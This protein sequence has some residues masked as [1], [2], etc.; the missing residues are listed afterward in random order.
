MTAPAAQTI[1][2]EETLGILAIGNNLPLL[3]K[4]GAEFVLN[5]SKGVKPCCAWDAGS[6]SRKPHHNRVE[7]HLCLLLDMGGTH[8][9]VGYRDSSG[10]WNPILDHHNDWFESKRDPSLP[11]L[12]AFFRTL[13]LE[14]L[15]ACPALIT[16][17]LPIRLGVI[18]S[19]QIKTRRFENGKTRGVTG[20]V[21]GYQSGGYRKGEWFLKEIKNGDD[22]GATLLA[23]CE[24]ASLIPE[25][26]VLG[27]DTLF[28]LF[29]VADAHA[30]VVMS[31]G[32]NCTLVGTED[33]DKDELFNSELGGMLMIPAELLSAGDVAFMKSR[34]ISSLSLEELSAG[35]WFPAMVASHIIEASVTPGGDDLKQLADDIQA[36]RLVV[37][38]RSLSGFLGGAETIFSAYPEASRSALYPLV[39]AL[40]E[41]GA[42]L[43]GLLC[44]LSVV[45]QIQAGLKVAVVSLDSS[46]A[47]HFP[48]YLEGMKRAVA[49][50]SPHGVTIDLRLMT[51]L[52]IAEGIEISVPLQGAAA[53]LTN[54]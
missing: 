29:A 30:G 24:R 12:Q 13:L 21:H 19:N 50:L 1:P 11:R 15:Q 32:G 44:Y 43:A 28:T 6:L 20:L 49:A 53:A 46:M 54:H 48:L 5:A 42:I 36:K 45:G 9:K 4:L 17:K 2:L 39:A 23:E 41:R 8:T 27:N 47:R 33:R 52:N 25:V 22:V 18:W 31:S 16:T 40:V 51:P 38:N 7:P 26:M 35:T 3:G 10:S 37:T 34:E 14:T